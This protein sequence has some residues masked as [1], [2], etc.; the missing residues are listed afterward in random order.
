MTRPAKN[1]TVRMGIII[2]VP[3]NMVSLPCPHT[4]RTPITPRQCFPA[5][6][7]FIMNNF[8]AGFYNIV[9]ESHN[10][11]SI[12]DS[13]MRIITQVKEMVKIYVK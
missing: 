4:C 9:W 5:S 11:T 12:Q 8:K 7:A 3:V 10:I 6:L 2:G 13:R 1:F